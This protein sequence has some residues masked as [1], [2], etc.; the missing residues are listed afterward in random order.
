MHV[1]PGARRAAARGRYTPSRAERDRT[2]IVT[3]LRLLDWLDAH[4]LTLQTFTQTHLEV[5]LTDNGV[6]G[7][8]SVH[9][10]IA[11]TNQ[12][13]LTTGLKVPTQRSGEP[14]Q[15]VA[16]HE[17]LAML[18]RC[19]HDDDLPLDVRVAGA[20]LLLYGTTVTRIATLTVEDVDRSRASTFLRLDRKP[21]LLPGDWPA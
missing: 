1:R 20:L 9:A 3:A 13:R 21:V 19:L 16:A 11:W 7:A 10:F 5:W 15:F 8:R 6:H 12:R 14:N 18:R 4:H 2:A 17:H